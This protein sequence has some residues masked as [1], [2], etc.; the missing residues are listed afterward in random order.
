MIFWVFDV[1]FFNYIIKFYNRSVE[2]E[3]S[4]QPARC[5]EILLLFFNW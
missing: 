1:D 3:L 4:N 2:W 5:F